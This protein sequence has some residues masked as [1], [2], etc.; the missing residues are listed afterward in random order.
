M[1][2]KNRQD[3]NCKI[4]EISARLFKY[5]GLFE[6][7]RLY[8]YRLVIQ[9]SEG[10]TNI[11]DISARLYKNRQIIRISAGYTNIGRLY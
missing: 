1:F 2:N 8:E 11:G 10:Y 5:I 3:K 6:Y 7:R 4:I 9:V